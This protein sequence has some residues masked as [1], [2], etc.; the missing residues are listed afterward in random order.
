MWRTISRNA[1]M[2]VLAL[3]ACCG[4]GLFVVWAAHGFTWSSRGEAHPPE[5]V[6]RSAS[7]GS[8]VAA[9]PKV[10]RPKAGVAVPR[11]TGLTL[12]LLA[13]GGEAW[14]SLRRGSAK[15]RTLYEGLLPRS[16]RLTVT[17]SRLV[18]RFQATGNLVALLQG[19]RTNLA[20]YELRQVLITKAGIRLLQR[21]R[22]ALV[23]AV[24]AS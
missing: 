24:R 22:T 12:T 2:A 18:G 15:G 11:S 16:H 1:D 20:P 17:G 4:L 14:V 13:S 8:H 19:R 9:P 21:P 6:A 3:A 5:R 7:T 23:P 10:A